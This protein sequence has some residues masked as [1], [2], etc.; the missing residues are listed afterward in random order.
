MVLQGRKLGGSRW[1]SQIGLHCWRYSGRSRPKKWCWIATI[2][3]G[4]A[5]GEFVTKKNAAFAL[6]EWILGKR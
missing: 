4:G 6:G 3:R 5:A 2:I 1:D